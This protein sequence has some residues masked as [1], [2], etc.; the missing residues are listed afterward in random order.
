MTTIAKS[1]GK[2]AANKPVDVIKIQALVNNNDLYTGLTGPLAVNGKADEALSTAIANFQAKHPQIAA[3]KP[4]GKVDPGGRTLSRLDQCNNVRGI[5]VDY[6]PKGFAGNTLVR[7]NI[8]TFL[9]LYALQYPGLGSSARVALKALVDFI[10]GDAEV[11]DLRWAA[12]M[13]ATVKHE[14]ADT[15]EP[16]EEY[17]KGAGHDYGNAV[18][19]K[20][21]DSK[22]ELSNTYYGRGYV[23]LT[24]ESNYKA[25]DTALGLSGLASLHLY[26][27]N[28]LNADTAY[29]IM[30]YGM[31]NG[32]FTGKKLSDYISSGAAD[33][34]NARRIINGVD[35]AARIKGYAD[36][37]EFLLRFCNGV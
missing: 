28:A 31:R 25:M 20:V 7:F 18:K 8:D 14:C 36:D 37:I 15:W 29:K 5:S 33:Y 19:V 34:R 22:L 6:Y 13:L 11:T 2:G 4:D 24:W 10:L 9:D 32:S 35:Q 1:V 16:I 12:Y 23:Q 30:S 26:P 17:G 21:P 3:K 27:A